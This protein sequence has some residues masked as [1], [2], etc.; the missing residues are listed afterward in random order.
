MFKNFK[1]TTVVSGVSIMLLEEAD[2]KFSNAIIRIM[3]AYKERENSINKSAIRFISALLAKGLITTFAA[4]TIFEKI[5]N[6]AVGIS[7]ADAGYEI[8]KTVR[9]ACEISDDKFIEMANLIES[10]T[11]TDLID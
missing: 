5:A 1:S 8:Y 2:K 10:K 7:A 6:F 9:L 3:A 4:D 11:L